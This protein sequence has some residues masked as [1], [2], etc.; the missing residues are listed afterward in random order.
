MKLQKWLKYYSKVKE[1]NKNYCAS[2]TIV[3]NNK[4]YAM[5]DHFMLKTAQFFIT[6]ASVPDTFPDHGFFEGHNPS[7]HHPP[8]L[9]LIFL[10]PLV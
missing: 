9:P 4:R 8:P 2:D 6:L 10:H 3:Q 5:R 7:H 1:M